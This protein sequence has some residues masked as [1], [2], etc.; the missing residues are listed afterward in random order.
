MYMYVQ[1]YGKDGQ[2]FINAELKSLATDSMLIRPYQRTNYVL[3]HFKIIIIFILQVYNHTS[4][5]VYHIVES[6][7]IFPYSFPN[8]LFVRSTVKCIQRTFKT[9][10][11]VFFYCQFK[12]ILQNDAY[13]FVVNIIVQVNGFFTFYA[14]RVRLTQKLLLLWNNQLTS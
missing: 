4:Y 2:Q 7:I 12:E 14:Q 10:T 3:K 6:C 8:D 1:L 5:D 9:S 11:C 13:C